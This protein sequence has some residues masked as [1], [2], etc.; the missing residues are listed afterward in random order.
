MKRLYASSKSAH[1]SAHA[2]GFRGTCATAEPDITDN[3]A[4]RTNLITTSSMLWKGNTQE[5]GSDPPAPPLLSGLGGART[6][7]WAGRGQGSDA[8]PPRDPPTPSPF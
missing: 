6:R 3:N 1:R 4:T 5:S 2:S 8:P 7:T